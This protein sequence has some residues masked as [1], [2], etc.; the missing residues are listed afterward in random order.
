MGKKALLYTDGA[1]RGNPGK[2]ALAYLIVEDGRIILEHGERI[3]KATNNEA[4]YR[5]LIAGLKAAA[6]LDVHEVSV[7]SDSELMVKQMRGLYAV[8]S[9]RL[10]PLFRQ[11]QEAK[12][13]FEHITFTSVPRE[14]SFI[15]KADL[16][17]NDALD[18]DSNSPLK[19]VSEEV[20]VRPIGF[21]CSPYK[22]VKDAPC[23]GRL[24]PV[25]STIEIHPQYE[26]GLVGLEKYDK[27]FILSWFDQS[28]RDQLYVENPGRGDSRGVFATRSPNRPNPVGL[29]L[30]DLLD[31]HERILHVR[32]LDALNGTPILDIK[33]YH[34]DI[35][36][37]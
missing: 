26:A 30:V 11:A 15:K 6:S 24:D 9:E 13:M 5:A 21:V 14:N 22:A 12:S 10:L 4:E 20:R 28:S 34:P 18:S 16:L 37:D 3:G 8:R 27:I 19:N 32:G 31:I 17:A 7:F 25:E 1:S 23:Q 2:A 35:D 36:S 33:P 29:T